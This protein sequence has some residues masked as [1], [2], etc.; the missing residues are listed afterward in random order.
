VSNEQAANE[1]HDRVVAEMKAAAEALKTF[2]GEDLSSL[3]PPERLRRFLD[4]QQAAVSAFNTC[5]RLV[6]TSS[7]LGALEDPY[8]AAQVAGTC[9]NA[10]DSVCRFQEAFV[11][12]ARSLDLPDD[13]T[14]P[15]PAAYCEMQHIVKEHHPERVPGLR[16]R[17]VEL[18]LPVMGFDR[19]L[20]K[21]QPA[22]IEFHTDG[23]VHRV[24]GLTSHDAAK[25]LTTRTRAKKGDF[26]MTGAFAGD[27]AVEVARAVAV[28]AP[29]KRDGFW[30]S[31]LAEMKKAP[32]AILIRVG[33]GVVLTLLGWW[34]W[35]RF[36]LS[37]FRK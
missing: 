7:I 8:W 5:E 34:L 17:F 31:N 12:R 1:F 19:H 23:E 10:L 22:R 36:G 28:A 21:K 35:N 26:E 24:E 3:P 6:G 32:A 14:R 18:G 2:V 37:A 33:A 20:L 29:A 11:A 16:S 4:V 25:V 15:S 9:L 13:V 30:A 27:Q